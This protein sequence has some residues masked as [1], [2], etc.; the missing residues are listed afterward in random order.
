M[1]SMPEADNNSD[2]I[3]DATVRG[4]KQYNAHDCG[5]YPD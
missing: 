4:R 3:Y 1:A 2:T 5:E